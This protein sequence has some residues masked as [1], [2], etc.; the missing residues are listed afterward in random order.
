MQPMNCSDVH[1]CTWPVFTRAI[2]GRPPKVLSANTTIASKALASPEP[3]QPYRVA[4]GELW[5]FAVSASSPGSR[6]FHLPYS[7]PVQ[8]DWSGHRAYCGAFA[9]PRSRPGRPVLFIL[10]RHAQ[11]S[12][13]TLHEQAAASP[14][15]VFRRRGERWCMPGAHQYRNEQSGQKSGTAALAELR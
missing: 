13:I 7:L 1:T 15:S 6:P 4:S 5:L 3:V 8:R 11:P 14:L 9:L 2:I 12:V 10:S